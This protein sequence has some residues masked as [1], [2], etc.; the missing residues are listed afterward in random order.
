MI[1]KV[2]RH[3]RF[4]LDCAHFGDGVLAS[5]KL[6]LLAVGMPLKTRLPVLRDRAVR[7]RVKL[8]GTSFS[9]WLTTAGDLSVFN[10]VFVDDGYAE[11]ALVSPTTILDL[12]ANIGLAALYYAARYP[13]ATIDCVEPDPRAFAALE[14]NTSA[15]PQIKR[16]NMAAAGADGT[17]T[18]RLAPLTFASGITSA[19][20][21]GETITVEARSLDTLMGSLAGDRLDLLKL[22]VEGAEDQILRG[23]TKLDHID[24]IAGEIHV[25]L[26]DATVDGVVGLLDGFQV[27]VERHPTAATFERYTFIAQ[28]AA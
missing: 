3:I 11:P 10:E 25:G 12:G 20:D 1:D 6:F 9:C 2:V 27:G 19:E 8:A 26:M 13:G 5:A 4:G 22:D 28:R 18:F 21:D 24:A 17:L 16:H 23:A 14:R 7:V 15:F